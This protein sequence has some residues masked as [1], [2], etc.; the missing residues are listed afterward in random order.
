MA[1]KKTG[2]EPRGLVALQRAALPDRPLRSATTQY[3]ILGDGVGQG[4]AIAL[5]A[6]A[7]VTTLPPIAID[8]AYRKARRL[9]LIGNIKYVSQRAESYRL[10]SKLLKKASAFVVLAC[11]AHTP[12][13]KFVTRLRAAAP[14][15]TRL[16]AACLTCHSPG[17]RGRVQLV[18][19]WQLLLPRGTAGYA[20]SKYVADG[21]GA[22][23][24]SLPNAAQRKR[25]LATFRRRTAAAMRTC[26]A[27]KKIDSAPTL[28]RLN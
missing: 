16:Y 5:K 6:I 7:A 11:R 9:R 28:K 19:G 2:D 14:R 8:P 24:V 3:F 27:K 10:S 23:C 1:R 21:A 22:C 17:L 4:M 18:R 15:G 12:V 26:I 25:C 13:G 20:K